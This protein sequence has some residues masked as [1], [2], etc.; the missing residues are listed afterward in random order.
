MSIV[1]LEKELAEARRRLGTMRRSTCECPP[2]VP[3][4]AFPDWL[5]DLQIMPRMGKSRKEQEERGGTVKG[6]FGVLNEISRSS[7]F[8]I[9]L[10]FATPTLAFTTARLLAAPRRLLLPLPRLL[11]PHHLPLRRST[12]SSPHSLPLLPLA[13]SCSSLPVGTERIHDALQLAIEAHST[14]EGLQ[15][16]L[17]GED[18]LSVSKDR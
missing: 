11:R 3:C 6:R 18:A 14:T 8:I 5:M 4:S 13:H 1:T 9:L 10:S 2:F 16:A 15:S 12:K 17:V 7:S